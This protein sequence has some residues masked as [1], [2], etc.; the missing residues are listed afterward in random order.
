MSDLVVVADTHLVRRDAELDAF[1]RFLDSLAGRTAVLYHLGDLFNIWLGKRRFEM[2]HMRPVLDAFRRLK[3]A[4]TSV[5]LVEGNR[6]FH[7]EDGYLDDPFDRVVP[8]GEAFE[9]AGRHFWVSHGDLVNDADRQYRTW[10][11]FSKSRGVWAAVSL[12]P[13]AAG[14]ALGNAL[15]ARLRGTNLRHKS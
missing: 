5:R 8:E 2:A 12:L 4:G 11:R 1:V 7:V 6:D 13:S 15:E 10:R 14:V 3:A 9:F